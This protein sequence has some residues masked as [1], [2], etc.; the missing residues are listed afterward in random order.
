MED[1][2]S[3]HHALQEDPPVRRPRVPGDIL[4]VLVYATLRREERGGLRKMDARPLVPKGT[5]GWKDLVVPPPSR[6]AL[7]EGRFTDWLASR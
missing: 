2:V 1:I 6:G 3:G 5:G 4:S 7:P